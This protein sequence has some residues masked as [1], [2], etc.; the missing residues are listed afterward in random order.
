MRSSEWQPR[1]MQIL[2]FVGLDEFKDRRAGQLSGGMKQK[3]GLATALVTR[4][5][6]LLLDEPFSAVDAPTRQ[7]LY[8]ELAALRQQVSTPM[9]LVTHDRSLARRLDRVLELHE[10]KLRPLE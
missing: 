8:R 2:E 4:P 1:C 10:G 9:V 5:R 7:T 3:L 6:V